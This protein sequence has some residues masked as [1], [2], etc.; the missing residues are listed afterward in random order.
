LAESARQ[1][2]SQPEEVHGGG[3]EKLLVGGHRRISDWENVRVRIEEG[4]S[5]GKK[6]LDP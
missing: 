4:G 5:Q 2:G 6:R 1:E 3:K